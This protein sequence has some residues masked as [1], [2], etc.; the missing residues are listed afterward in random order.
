MN[1]A[2]ETPLAF[3]SWLDAA[4]MI[5]E[6]TLSPLHYTQTLLERI[7]RLDDSLHAFVQVDVEGAL[8]AAREAERL[9]DRGEC[10][11]PMHGV[12]FALKDIIDAAGLATTCQSRILEGNVAREDAGVTARLRAAGGILLG[13]LTTH[14]FAIGGPCFDL[15]RPPAC[16]PWQ[17]AHFTGG[18]SSGS[19]AAIA[20]GL[21]PI[22]IG[23]DTGGSVRNP[24]TACGIVGMKP[25]YGRI[26]RRG[27]FPLAFSLD[28]VGPM[29]RT[30][31]ENAALL[32]VLAGHDAA[33]PGSAREPVPDF[34]C[35]LERGV[36]GMRIGLIRRFHT[37]DLQASA[38]VAAAIEAAAEVL[39]GL[40]A[41][42]V[43]VDTPA[44][45]EYVDCNRVILLSE[46]CAVHER[47]LRERPGD[48]AALT[49]ER[50]LAGAF[51]R[52][53]D[54]VQAT[55]MRRV[56]TDAMDAA[57]SGVDVAICV[58]SHDPPCRLDD[59]QENTRTYQRQARAP[60]NLTG[61][62]ALAIPCG[63]SDDGLPIG[64][65]VVGRAFDEATLYR[66]AHAY[67]QASP[68]Q[69]RRP[70]I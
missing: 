50:L 43:E 10:A 68:W 35:D 14:E 22:A 51:L 47:W 27:V 31:A 12:P 41:E 1:A 56:L 8:A 54:Y 52:A 3:A 48:Y 36:H 19:G 67:E 15:P 9:R 5:R 30:V 57:L 34:S 61:Q 38:P 29:T 4:R 46:A 40:G 53:V 24:A 60:F 32:A 20:A 25:T 49:R 16:N 23:T 64:L 7:E 44:L 55:R 2:D 37:R 17:R 39:A 11:G 26:S 13:K 18:S 21:A 62:P 65:Q 70:A 63:F 58:S 69:A 45:R 28:T 66:V 59:A 42:V 33:D 6:G